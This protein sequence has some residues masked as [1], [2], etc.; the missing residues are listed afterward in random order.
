M[1]GSNFLLSFNFNIDF[2]SDGTRDSWFICSLFWRMEKQYIRNYQEHMYVILK[3]FIN[4]SIL[5]F[6]K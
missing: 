2:Q 3:A 5:I 4:H 1:I 6:L